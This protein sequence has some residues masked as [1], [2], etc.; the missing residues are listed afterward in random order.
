[1]NLYYVISV[2][3]GYVTTEYDHV[4]YKLRDACLFDTQKEARETA[5]S[6]GYNDFQVE[7]CTLADNKISTPNRIER[8]E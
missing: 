1:M 8:Y 5:R 6:E 4:S 3:G 7:R 2:G